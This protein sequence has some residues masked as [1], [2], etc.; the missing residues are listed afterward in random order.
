[1]S[2]EIRRNTRLR[3]ERTLMCHAAAATH[4]RD[5][6]SRYG[7]LHFIVGRGTGPRQGWEHPSA[8]RFC[9]KQDGQDAQDEQ[10]EGAVAGDRPPRYKKNAPQSP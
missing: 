1:M 7:I 4:A 6:P 8:A 9:L 3:S 5:R 2:I 10:D